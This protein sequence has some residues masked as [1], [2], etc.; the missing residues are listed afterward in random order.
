MNP[1]RSMSEDELYGP[2]PAYSLTPP[3]SIYVIPG[4]P[5]EFHERQPSYSSAVLS[6]NTLRYLLATGF[7]H[8]CIGI[9]I[10]VCDILLISMNESYSFTGFWA[11]VLC[12]A[13]GI[14]VILFMGNR[15]KKSCSLQRFKLIH[16]AVF[17][18]SIASLVLSILNLASDFC[19]DSY[20]SLFRCQESAKKLKIVIV[21]LFSFT[22]VQ[23]CITAIVIFIYTR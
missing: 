17:L 10:I 19:N 1:N 5:I 8:L 22:C 14:Y 6:T 11:G 13:L 16:L 12:L 20:F 2:P 18:I 7:V 9:A 21:T 15:K 23:I 3:P 4:I